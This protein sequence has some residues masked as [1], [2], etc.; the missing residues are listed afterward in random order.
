MAQAI[1]DKSYKAEALTA[2]V[3]Q[4]VTR[5]RETKGAIQHILSVLTSRFNSLFGDSNQ[6]KGSEILEQAL[7]V[8]NSTAPKR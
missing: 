3:E 6:D 8:V 1:K 5:E 4:Y 2:I 7:Q